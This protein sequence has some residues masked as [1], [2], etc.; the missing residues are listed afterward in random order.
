HR[1]QRDERRHPVD[2]RRRG[3]GHSHEGNENGRR[4]DGPEG[5]E[6]LCDPLVQRNG[7]YREI[8][9]SQSVLGQRRSSLPTSWMA[10]HWLL[11]VLV[12]ALLA[13]IGA[14]SLCLYAGIYNV[15]ADAPHT[16]PVYWF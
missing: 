1:H 2:G 11:A 15:A 3:K 10:R 13:A 8:D 5:H 12:A 7:S 14:A 16:Q 9:V 4:D 6:G